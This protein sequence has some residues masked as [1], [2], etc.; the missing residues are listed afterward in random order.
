MKMPRKKLTLT[1]IAIIVVCAAL[2]VLTVVGVVM[3]LDR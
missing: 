1:D 3:S 2:I